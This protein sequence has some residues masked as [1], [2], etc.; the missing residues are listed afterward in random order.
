MGK[1][2]NQPLDRFVRGLR[3]KQSIGTSYMDTS[4]KE[5]ARAREAE[6]ARL[7]A[8]G[9]VSVTKLPYVPPKKMRRR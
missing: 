8:E 5:G 4:D 1:R 9:G 7:I 6:G 2:F 3:Y